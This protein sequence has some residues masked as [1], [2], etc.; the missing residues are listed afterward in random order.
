[1]AGRLLGRQNVGEVLLTSKL[2][3]LKRT[4]NRRPSIALS[5]LTGR[6]A[7]QLSILENFYPADPVVVPETTVAEPAAPI[8]LH[9]GRHFRARTVYMSEAQMR[10]ID[11]IIQA[12]REVGAE[13]IFLTRSAV[14]RRAVTFL[15]AAVEADPAKSIQECE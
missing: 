14:L 12:W 8:L 7:E 3:I 13:R 9:P 11:R 15:R 10:D 6:V 4:G 2:E 5:I 1:M